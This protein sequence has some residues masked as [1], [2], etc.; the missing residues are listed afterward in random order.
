MGQSQN[1]RAVDTPE[2]FTGARTGSSASPMPAVVRLAHCGFEVIPQMATPQM[3]ALD[4][5]LAEVEVP[6]PDPA[7]WPR[8]LAGVARQLRA[9]LGRHRDTLPCSIGLLS[10]SGGRALRFHE[11]VLAIMRAGGL[12]DDW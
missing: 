2:G 5:A 3:M 9:A 12:P 4:Q 11:R 6:Q 10:A 1:S 8:Q 7:S